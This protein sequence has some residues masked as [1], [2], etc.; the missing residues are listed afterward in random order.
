[1]E[2]GRKERYKIVGGSWVASM[3]GAFW[4]VGRNP[5]LTGQQKLVQARVYAQGLTLAVLVASAAFE[6]SEQR[7]D[8]EL[9]RQGKTPQ[10]EADDDKR[11][12]QDMWKDMVAAEEDRLKRRDDAIKKQ[13]ERDRKAGKNHHHKKQNGQKPQEKKKDDDDKK[14][15]K[16]NDD[17]QEEEEGPE[18]IPGKKGE[19]KRMKKMTD[20]PHKSDVP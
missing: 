3:V 16:K 2:F 13:E 17:D 11:G 14:D 6:I 7:R 19:G 1:M 9:E 15:D 12:E 8:E 4:L 20:K 10:H 5:Y 18:P